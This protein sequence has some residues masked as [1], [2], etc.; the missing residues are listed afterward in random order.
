MNCPK[1]AVE[2]E[3]PVVNVQD[4]SAARWRDKDFYK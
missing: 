2:I 4:G 3:T 1:C